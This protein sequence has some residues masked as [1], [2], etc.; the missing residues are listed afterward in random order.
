MMSDDFRSGSIASAGLKGAG[1]GAAIGF[2]LWLFSMGEGT[3]RIGPIGF[4]GDWVKSLGLPLSGWL[5]STGV[6]SMT[7]AIIGVVTDV[8]GRG[9]TALMQEVADREGL[10][11]AC[12]TSP[13]DVLGGPTMLREV[14]ASGKCNSV[15]LQHS[16][17]GTHDGYPLEIVDLTA[18]IRGSKSN[19]YRR[20]TVCVMPAEGLPDFV[21]T[22]RKWHHS[23]LLFLGFST[24]IRYAA[25][26]LASSKDGEVVRK[27]DAAWHLQPTDCATA[28]N[29]DPEKTAQ[30]EQ[31]VRK[32]F[33][34]GLM[35]SLC[36]LE[37]WSV[38]VRS[39]WIVVWRGS[40]F[41]SAEERQQLAAAT[42]RLRSVLVDAFQSPVGAEVPAMSGDTQEKRTQR[43]I[44]SALGGVLGGVAGFFG[45]FGTFVAYKS[46]RDWHVPDSIE[47]ALFFVGPPLGLALGGLAGALAG[48]IFGRFFKFKLRPPAAQRRELSGWVAAGL[49]L[50]FMLGGIAGMAFIMLTITTV[51]PGRVPF[52]LMMPAFFAFPI[53]GL[54]GG[55]IAGGRIQ[56]R[57][58]RRRGDF[59]AGRP[60][61]LVEATTEQAA[62]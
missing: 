60:L 30:Q 32:L 53:L 24:R 14:F 23:L 52:W 48:S 27:F 34:A 42:A 21:L 40:G 57:R 11:Y 16:Y 62:K 22:P 26:K 45:G 18:I 33:T 28:L 31:R 35:D 39:G 9:R 37:G 54:I 61:E 50:G 3:L 13:D 47:T 43:S 1:V 17:R 7:G 55:A 59:A 12:Q 4:S 58:A 36:T 5:L 6:G 41:C 10:Q 15:K 51:G 46:N 19:S 56:A 8:R 38:A 29:T 44:G 2:V 25:K 20:R 49:F